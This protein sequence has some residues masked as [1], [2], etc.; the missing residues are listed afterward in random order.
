[1]Q[2]N[3]ATLSSLGGLVL[4]TVRIRFHPDGSL[5]PQVL[6]YLAPLS[7][8]NLAAFKAK[9]YPADARVGAAGLEQSQEPFL[10]GKPGGMLYV[11]ANHRHTR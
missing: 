4:N 10:A 8:E 9:G 2:A 11:P 7:P 6:G 5:A 3:Y 1:V